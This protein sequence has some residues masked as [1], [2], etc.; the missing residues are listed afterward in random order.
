MHK[1]LY[2]ASKSKQR[3]RL[4]HE[5][6]IPFELI[7][8]DADETKC[9]W[10]MPLQK[11][12][13]S[14]AQLKMEHVKLSASDNYNQCWVLTADT[15]CI[16]SKGELFGKPKDKADAIRMVK[17][18]R[19]G[20]LAGTGFCIDRRIKQGKQWLL[21]EHYIGYA[22]GECFLDIPDHLIEDYFKKLQKLTGLNY[23]NLSGAFSITGIGA[24]FVKEVHGSYTAILG[25]PMCEVRE[26]LN[27]LGFFD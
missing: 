16:D 6:D 24:Q 22:Q 20:A 8:Q 2:L 27:K 3:Q 1:K 25:L 11:L 13:E 4:L 21:D 14:L 10:G 9:E 23:L 12:T 5:A 18:V 7:N 19:D 26:G 17:A 15:L